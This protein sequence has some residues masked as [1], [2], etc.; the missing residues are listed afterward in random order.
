MNHNKW[1]NP[2]SNPSTHLKNHP[3]MRTQ[4]VDPST[5]A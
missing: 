2:N 3:T 4:A 5:A 1:V